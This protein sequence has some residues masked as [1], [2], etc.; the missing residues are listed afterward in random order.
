MDLFPLPD[1]YAVV[2]WADLTEADRASVA[3]FD[4]PPAVDPFQLPDLRH[5]PTSLALRAGD[6][7][8]GWCVTHRVRPDTL[9]LT[10]LWVSPALRR[11]G[12]SLA[13]LVEVGRRMQDTTLTRGLFVVEADN[14]PMRR[15][16]EDHLVPF[17]YLQT[18][19]E[20]RGSGK[21]LA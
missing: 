2:P 14:A 17:G 13:L 16:I 8:A 7:L 11:Q 12:L 10:A 15:F 3:A 20:V 5:E 4:V 1:G 6:A 19:A 18:G 9:Q 21:R